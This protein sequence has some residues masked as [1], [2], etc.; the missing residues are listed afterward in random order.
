[1]SKD[2]PPL[3]QEL[4]M[5]VG[6]VITECERLPDGSGFAIMSMPLPKD[7]WIYE[8]SPHPPAPLRMGV[9]NPLR[10]PLGK[11]IRE[12]GKYAVRA[13]TMSGKDMDFDPDA[14]LQNL[15]VGLLGYFTED[16]TSSLL[17]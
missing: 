10:E 17:D 7:H 12:V 8:D 15:V 13:S 1:M 9:G 11:M 2:V 14:M 3:I 4:A 6:G 16:G 5:G